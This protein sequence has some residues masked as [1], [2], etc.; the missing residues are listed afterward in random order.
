MNAGFVPNLKTL[1]I[2][3]HRIA[4]ASAAVRRQRRNNLRITGSVQ[5]CKNS[6]LVKATLKQNLR[7]KTQVDSIIIIII[8]QNVCFLFCQILQTLKYFLMGK[9]FRYQLSTGNQ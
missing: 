7:A 8:S 5:H 9:P 3:R 2:V 1:S 4:W 6:A